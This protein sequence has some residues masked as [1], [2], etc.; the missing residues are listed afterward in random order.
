MEKSPDQA[1]AVRSTPRVL[2]IGFGNPGRCDDGLGPALADRLAML[3]M[4]GVSIE[5]DYQLSIEHAAL[6]AGHDVVVFAD[7]ATDV[8]QGEPYYLRPIQPAPD[9]SS[10]TH[11]VSPRAVLQLAAE[12]F[13]ARPRAWLLGIRPV[14]VESF[15]EALTPPAERHLEAALA[16]LRDLLLSLQTDGP[17]VRRE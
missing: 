8:S 4:P 17:T 9:V 5:S 10:F 16:A 7:A 2:V 13:N 11:H 1:P 15:S 14:D 3:A 12:C 6:V